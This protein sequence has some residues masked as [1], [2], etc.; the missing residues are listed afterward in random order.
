ML[1]RYENIRSAIE[2]IDEIK[3]GDIY[4]L[5]E[6]FLDPSTWSSIIMLPD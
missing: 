2:I 1:G 6:K 5:G 3:P 4:A